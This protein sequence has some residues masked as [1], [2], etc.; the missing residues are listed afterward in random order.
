[1]HSTEDSSDGVIFF[2][3]FHDIE[4]SFKLNSWNQFPQLF[5]LPKIKILFFIEIHVYK[6]MDPHEY[7]TSN[8]KDL[9]QGKFGFWN[10]NET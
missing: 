9:G 1:M 4:N 8:A 6:L 2:Y 7:E 3:L 10:N 5:I